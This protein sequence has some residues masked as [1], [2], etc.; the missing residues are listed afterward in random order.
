MSSDRL[1]AVVGEGEEDLAASEDAFALLEQIVEH[2]LRR[3]LTTVVDTLGLDPARR[4]AWLAARAAARSGD[5]RGRVRDAGGRVPRPQPGARQAGARRRARRQQVRRVGEQRPRPR[6]RGLRHRARPGRGAHRAA[7]R[8]PAPRALTAQQTEAP[9]GLRF[10]LQIPVWS[11]PGRRGGAAAPPHRGRGRRRGGR[12]REHLGDGPLPPDPDVRR[13]VAGH[14]RELDHARL[15]RRRDRAGPA[16]HARHRHHLPERRPP[17]EDRRHPRRALGRAGDVRA[18]RSA[19]SRRSTAPTAGRSRPT[20]ERYALLEDALQ[21][22]PVLWGKG[23]PAFEG[24][25]LEVPEAMCYPRPL[26]ERIPILVGGNGER[27]TLR[28]AA[29]YADACN[30]IGEA[31][32]VAR[33]VAALHAHCDVAGPRPRRGRGHPAVHHARRPRRRRGG[34]AGR[35]AAAP[36]APRRALRGASVNAGTV[37][38]QI[39]RFRALADAGVQHRHRQ[40]PRPRSDTSRPSNASAQ[41][42]ERSATSDG[43]Q[44]AKPRNW[45][46]LASSA[47]C[48]RREASARIPSSIRSDT[49][50]RS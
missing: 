31:D 1:R 13:G 3:R 25:A 50:A 20:A 4:A 9:V 46:R 38:D 35:A 22:L 29:R 48:S 23:S 2:R 6:G 41:I 5:R 28:L 37:D 42:I 40:P 14:A 24:R 18:R 15:P 43:V 47:E 36:Q 45:Q 16:R 32:V 19:G 21:L 44:P 10:G 30:V 12:L 17:R 49:G 11:W 27:R 33:K 8:W 7:R 34:G 39:G 26:Q